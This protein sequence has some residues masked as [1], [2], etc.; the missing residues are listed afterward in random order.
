MRIY[1]L[2]LSVVCVVASSDRLA[3]AQSYD[4]PANYYATATGTGTTLKSQLH[5]IIDG[6]TIVSY[7]GARTALQVTDRDP[8]NASRILLVYNRVSN[9]AAWDSA[10][11]WNREHTWPESRLG[12][13]GQSVN[14]TESAVRIVHKPTNIVVFSQEQRSQIQNREVCMQMLRA[15]LYEMERQAR[16]AA[17]AADRK[18]QVGSGDRSER[19]RTYNFPQGRVT[20]HRINLTLY[21]I[22]KV[23][24]GEALDEIVEALIADDE[25]ARLADLQ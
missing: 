22:D 12:A 20:D 21:K 15:R 11:T 24:E 8:N 6:H 4:P 5:D 13:G 14:R 25:A 3:S 7:D 16:D 10:A 23:M 17:R 1:Y 9:T 2:L 19:I 18:S